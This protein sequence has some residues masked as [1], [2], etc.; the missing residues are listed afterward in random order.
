MFFTVLVVHPA[1]TASDT[2]DK[3]NK[4]YLIT[5]QRPVECRAEDLILRPEPRE[6]KY[7]RERKRSGKEGQVSDRHLFGQSAHVV[8]VLDMAA[9]VDNRACAE[10]EE[11]FEIRM[12]EKMKHACCG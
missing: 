7:P 11:R 8:D 9:A 5:V 3:D 2:E 12:G 1:N 4:V 10:K 6:W